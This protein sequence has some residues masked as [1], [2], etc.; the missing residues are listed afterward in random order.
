[1]RLQRPRFINQ[2][3]RHIAPFPYLRF[4]RASPALSIVAYPTHRPWVGHPVPAKAVRLVYCGFGSCAHG[5]HPDSWRG[6]PEVVNGPNAFETS[7][8][9]RGFRALNLSFP[10]SAP[11]DAFCNECRVELSV[12]LKL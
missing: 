6:I 12:S 5:V 11:P 1:L 9:S 2:D 7:A 3:I 10:S 8:P 4:N